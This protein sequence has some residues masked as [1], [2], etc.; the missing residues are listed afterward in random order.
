MPDTFVLISIT[1]HRA[2]LFLCSQCFK[3]GSSG[4]NVF[5]CSACQLSYH[6]TCNG[7]IVLDLSPS[8]DCRLCT[9][10]IQSKHSA[11]AQIVAP[12]MKEEEGEEKKMEDRAEASSPKPASALAT[13]TP[14]T[15]AAVAAADSQSFVRKTSLSSASSISASKKSLLKAVASSKLTSHSGRGRPRKSHAS[16][17]PHCQ[18]NADSLAPVPTPSQHRTNE[19]ARETTPAEETSA[20]AQQ[21]TAGMRYYMPKLRSDNIAALAI[22]LRKIHWLFV[23]QPTTSPDVPPP[24]YSSSHRSKHVS[25]SSSLDPAASF[26]APSSSSD[27][28]PQSPPPPMP[29]YLHRNACQCKALFGSSRKYPQQPLNASEM[30]TIRRELTQMR[31]QLWNLVYALQTTSVTR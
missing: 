29:D 8:D 27:T 28:S 22:F 4:F 7:H 18:S 30:K 9:S 3:C 14:T 1:A 5:T 6:S 21:K 12:K 23:H 24:A 20:H 11:K 25:S 19:G 2:A 26:S 15:S 10:C 31:D 16:E 17:S 13:K